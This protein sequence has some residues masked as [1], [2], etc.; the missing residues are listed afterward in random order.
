MATGTDAKLVASKGATTFI[1]DESNMQQ[2]RRAPASQI[3]PAELTRPSNIQRILQK[4]AQVK[5]YPRLKKLEKLGV[6]SSCKV[7]IS[8]I[9]V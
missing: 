1:P 2:Q 4:K 5:A 6:Y 7:G 8:S 3:T 9:V